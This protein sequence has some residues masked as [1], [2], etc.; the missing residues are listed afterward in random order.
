MPLDNLNLA[1]HGAQLFR[2]AVKP[3][4][5][6]LLA[7]LDT[8]PSEQAGVRISGLTGLRPYLAPE[9]PIRRCGCEMPWP[10]R[11]GGAGDP[12]R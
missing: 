7:L 2:A 10:P 1:D 5:A 3:K 4:I 8:L 6:D 11:I 12:V 9:G